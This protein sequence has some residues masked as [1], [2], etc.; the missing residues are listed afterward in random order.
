[1]LK[2]LY[3]DN[4]RCLTN[5]ELHVD[6]INLFLG[7]NGTGKSTI[8]EVLQK[9]QIFVSDDRKVEGV[10]KKS[11]CTR[12]QKWLTQRFELEIFGNDGNYKYELAIEHDQDKSFVKYERL[13]FERQLLLK[14]ESGEVQLFR[15]NYSLEVTYSFDWS[16]SL[17]PSL[18]PKSDNTKLTW[19][20]ERMKRFIIVK[21]IP[22]LMVNSSDRSENHLSLHMENFV[23]WY[24]YLSQD[25][26]KVAELINILKEVMDGFV[27]FK[28]DSFSEDHRTLKLRF[29]QESFPT[30]L[31]DYRFDELS[32]GQKVLMALYTLLY[33]TQ[34]E[35]Y[36]LCIDEP[37]NFIALPEIQPW[38]SQL[39]DLCNEQKMQALLISHHPELINYLL[40]SPIGYWF[41]RQSN[42]PV[43]VKKI[44]NEASASTGLPISELIVRG[45][46]YES[47]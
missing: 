16:Q 3:I 21:I 2:R 34:S 27:S 22:S 37:E 28:F 43:R 29:S 5:F 32:D 1:M 36:T 39:Y 17:L 30:K 42:T 38:L 8:F 13:W 46:L 40:A 24:R 15:D 18:M 4:F 20:T 19:F 44:G 35:D 45:W 11:D 31:I 7:A 41:E 14:F 10:F 25:Q 9:I 12:W 33:G 26:G 47:A 6:S 23:S